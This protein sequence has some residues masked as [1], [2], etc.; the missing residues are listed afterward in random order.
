MLFRSGSGWFWLVLV[1]SGWFWLVLVGSCCLCFPGFVVVFVEFVCC[2]VCLLVVSSQHF[3]KTVRAE[4]A[5]L[6]FSIGPSGNVAIS[7]VVIKCP[8]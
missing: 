7:S 5:T 2:S 1:G 4:N 6:V 8:V 3:V